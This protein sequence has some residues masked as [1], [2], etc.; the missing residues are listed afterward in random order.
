MT[1][2]APRLKLKNR[3]GWFAAGI[4]IEQAL[5]LLPDG[6]FKTFIYICLH[7]RRDTGTLET[8]A[9]ALAKNLGKASGTVRSHLR[10]LQ[11]AGIC[12]CQLT[13]NRHARGV[14][15][16]AEAF[17][18]YDQ[19][20]ETAIEQEEAAYVDRVKKILL[21]QAC[22]RSTFSLADTRLAR[23][24]HA[25]GIPLERIEQAIL[26]GC[27]RKYV[28]WRNGRSRTPI[29]SLRY[30][31]ATLAEVSSQVVAPDYADYLRLKLRRLEKLWI[32]GHNP[33]VEPNYLVNR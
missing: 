6:A 1:D 12:R 13:Q 21:E 32:E 26:L 9:N 15:E 33:P 31:D 25:Q 22:V 18:P 11:A 19:E 27:V 28:S 3:T 10:E 23:E 5:K 20:S 24:W 14:I 7:A 16:I 29:G 8:S 4:E 2:S 17:W 30:F